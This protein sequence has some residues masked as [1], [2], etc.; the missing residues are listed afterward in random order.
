MSIKCKIIH[1]FTKKSIQDIISSDIFKLLHPNVCIDPSN[2]SLIHD[3]SLIIIRKNILK[4]IDIAKLRDSLNSTILICSCLNILPLHIHKMIDITVFYM[5]DP[6]FINP[7]VYERL[8]YFIPR[9]ITDNMHGI[10]N[11]L[12]GYEGGDDIIKISP[13]LY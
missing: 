12:Y 10:S 13:H 2:Y 3:N 1:V 11:E 5:Y 8:T 6:I 7:M 4:N 9:H